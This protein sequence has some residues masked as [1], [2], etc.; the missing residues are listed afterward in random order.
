M[1][2]VLNIAVKAMVKMQIGVLRIFLDAADSV[3][4]QVWTSSSLGFKRIDEATYHALYNQYTLVHNVRQ[5]RLQRCIKLIPS[6]EELVKQVH[7]VAI[8]LHTSTAKMH[9]CMPNSSALPIVNSMP[10]TNTPPTTTFPKEHVLSCL[11]SILVHSHQ[12]MSCSQHSARLFV[13]VQ[14]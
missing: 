9:D 7:L 4:F 6:Q 3:A 8:A 2:C 10:S 5:N 14:Y 1:R 11:D 12:S 13:T